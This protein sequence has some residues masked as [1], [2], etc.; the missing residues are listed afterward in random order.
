M[1]NAGKLTLWRVVQAI[2]S[3]AYLGFAARTL[4][5][6]GFGALVIIHTLCLAVAQLA[7]FETWQA[8]VR[9]GTP[10][11]QNSEPGELHKVIRFGLLLDLAG[12]G[13]AVLVFAALIWPVTA[14]MGLADDLRLF[15]F[16]YGVAAVAIMNAVD[17]ATG[18][19]HLL[20]RFGRLSI[21]SSFEPLIRFFGAGA[22]FFTGG[23]LK[24]FLAIWLVALLVSHSAILFAAF[25]ALTDRGGQWRLRLGSSGWKCAVPGMWRFACGT[26]WVGTLNVAQ[27]HFPL[28][29]VG[30][31][32]G[33]AG[34]G[35]F[36]VAKQFSD[37]LVGSTSKLLIPALFPEVARLEPASRRTVLI[38]I[39]LF[40]ITL[41]LLIFLLLGLFGKSW[42]RLV[43]GPEFENAFS[44]MLWLCL[45]GVIGATSFSVETLLTATGAI[46]HVAWIHSVSLVVYFSAFA[47]LIHPFGIDG[48]GMAAVA[49]AGT[50]SGLLWWRIMRF[51]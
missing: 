29:G 12:I 23:G 14:W 33:S 47:A 41:F 27:E 22:L 42:I 38:K 24:A 35:L 7:R 39:N 20:D 37:V 40:I 50:R 51:R 49:Q 17:S 19:L 8:M 11:L 34:A 15:V 46:R 18:L 30:A 16:I 4:G 1:R 36:K 3:L 31:V 32:L 6:A 25:R 13:L 45:A 10:P 28:L 43:A 5:P 21:A 48:V 44:A 9:F 26:H 2:C